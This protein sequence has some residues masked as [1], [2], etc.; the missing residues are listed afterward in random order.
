[1]ITGSW[2][3]TMKIHEIYA[4]KLNV[5]TLQHS[6]QITALAINPDGKFVAAATIK[7]EIYIWE[8]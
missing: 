7:G 6:S 4:R 2:D 8:L 3:R 1:M 5:E